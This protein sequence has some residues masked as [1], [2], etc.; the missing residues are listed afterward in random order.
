M[1][2]ASLTPTTQDFSCT[3]DG[4]TTIEIGTA[5]DHLMIPVGAEVKGTGITAGTYIKSKSVASGPTRYLCLMSAVSTVSSTVART[6]Y[7]NTGDEGFVDTAAATKGYLRAFSATFPVLLHMQASSL[8]GYDTPDKTSVYFTVSSPGAAASGVSLAPNSWVAGNRRQPHLSPSQTIRRT[9]MGIV[10][11]DSAAVIAYSDGIFLFQNR[12]GGISGEDEDQRLYT[13]NDTRGCISYLSLVSGNGWAAYCTPQGVIVVD[14]NARE[15]AVSGDIFN[16]S[17]M[18]GDLAYEITQ[19]SASTA[20]DSDNQ[21]LSMAIMGSKLAVGFRGS[22]TYTRLCFYDFSPGIEASG[23]EQ[24]LNPET[25]SAYIWSPPH[26]YNSTFSIGL[27]GAMGSVYG[28][29][30]RSDYLSY[31][32]NAGATGDGRIELIQTGTTDNNSAVTS[33]AQVAPLVPEPYTRVSAQ[34][35]EVT[36]RTTAASGI[37]SI[38]LAN[39]QTPTFNTSLSRL[40]AIDA[41]KLQYQKQRVPI[42]RGQA[43][44]AD[45]F[46][47]RWKSTATSVLN[48]IYRIVL[49]YQES[50]L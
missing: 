30:G 8:G 47:M 23:V 5:A 41:A 50:E 31:D 35:M 37:N 6:F 1:S 34:D 26:I 20:S 7:S 21:Y 32:D 49:R 43:G 4:T 46:W 13:V 24:L 28:A 45:I 9:C 29:S 10:D 2:S 3:T 42:D 48:R 12:K 19:S 38:E 16:P 22:N 18:S 40:L 44:P 25:K 27:T 11:I 33:Y 15:F 17:D 14:K 39:D 36:H